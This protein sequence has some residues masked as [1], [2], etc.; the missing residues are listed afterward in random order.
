MERAQPCLLQ[1]CLCSSC[2]SAQLWP[3]PHL[4]AGS[5]WCCTSLLGARLDLPVLGLPFPV[6]C[7]GRGMLAALASSFFLTVE[8]EMVNKDPCAVAEVE[9]Q[10]RAIYSE[11]IWALALQSVLSSCLSPGLLCCPGHRRDSVIWDTGNP[12]DA[13]LQTA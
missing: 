11:G 13:C 10:N 8:A 9:I 6:A 1:M 7:Q 5:P 12:L 2:C 4:W 3:V